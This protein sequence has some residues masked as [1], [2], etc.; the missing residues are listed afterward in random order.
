[1]KS[2]SNLQSLNPNT[3]LGLKVRAIVS[4]SDRSPLGPQS[5]KWQRQVICLPPASSYSGEMGQFTAIT[6]PFRV[7]KNRDT[8]SP[9][10]LNSK[11]TSN[12][13]HNV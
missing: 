2:L 5:Y 13:E 8:E 10:I 3:I 11:I 12:S 9:V 6:A 1:M 4:P 7:M